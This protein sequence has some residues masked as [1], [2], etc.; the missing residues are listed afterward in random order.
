MS[1]LATAQPDTEPGLEETPLYRG[2]ALLQSGSYATAAE[3][4]LMTDG[5]DRN[6]GIVGASKAYAMLGNYQQA[7]QVCEEAIDD[8][9]YARFPLISTQL[10]EIKR[11]TGESD[12]ALNILGSVINDNFEPPVRSLVQYGSLLQFKGRKTEA[13]SHLDAAVQRY[14]DG[15]VYTS[16]DITMVALA[17]WLLDNFHDANSLFNEATRADPN[18][19]EAHTLWADLFLEKYNAA[20][21]ERGYRDALEINNR[22]VPALIGI[23]KAVGDERSVRSA[24]LVNPNS[25]PA[26]ETWG[27]L[28][29]RGDKQEEATVYFNRAL[30]V[31]PEALD[32]LSVLAAEAA[33]AERM[34][35]YEDYRQQV[36]AFSPNNPHFLGTV[37]TTLGANYR[38]TE[39]VEYARAALDA[40]PSYWNGYSLLG[41]NLVRLGEEEEGK[42]Y[43]EIGFENDPF[44]LVTSNLLTVF[45]TLETYHTVES[46]HFK[47]HLSERDATILWPYLEPLL[48]QGWDALTAKYDFEPEA[49]VLIEIFE[50]TED[51]A[52]RSI[53]LPDIGPLVGI[54]FGKVVT[55]ISPDTLSANWQEI[56]WHEFAHVIT[57]QM[58]RNRIPRWLSEG[59][60]VWEEKQSRPYW[61]REQ[62]L[63]LV[64]GIREEK[65]LPVANLSAG[66]RDAR[67]SADLGFA[68]FQSYLVVD[69]ITSEF[70]FNK[71]VEL[72]KQYEQTIEDDA[73]FQAAFDMDLDLF[74]TR[75]RRWV[76]RRVNEI[77]VYVHSDDTPDEGEG[78]GHGIRENPSAILAELYN[79][80]ALIRHMLARVEDNPR[81]FQAHLQ[82]GI[83]YFKEENFTEAK[84]HLNI[85]YELLPG[86]T[87]YPSPA[88]VLSQIYAAEDDRDAELE[89]LRLLLEHQQHDAGSAMTLAR[90]A[91]DEEEYEQ[92]TYYINRV[93]EVDPYRSDVHQLKAEL[94]RTLDNPA[95][96]V[97]EYEVLLKLEINDPVEAYTNLAEAYLQNK[98]PAA[99]KQHV[100]YALEI[101]PGFRRAQQLLLDS[102]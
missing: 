6:E 31:N 22:Y 11:L 68:Y 40:D 93:L 83:A 34:D 5:L 15:L 70:G 91:L 74:N 26:L 12:T 4:F 67:N 2:E 102:L 79:N 29:L 25:A 16:E 44:N 47:V 58:T 46:E 89:Q 87:G 23:G 35:D 38:F 37:A 57:L 61:G 52:V 88:L 17:S 100:L 7:A 45:D 41:S 14:N 21:A 3:V 60:S 73:R 80:A 96:A 43:L 84:R 13:V 75:F 72:I 62:G 24:L 90:A 66:F 101:A 27:Q 8:D 48:E 18:N 42:A 94:A 82:L 19:L 69:F 54:C 59:I 99:A 53:G 56:V 77:D 39:A 32:T 85:A 51:F 78:H 86:Y 95:E 50:N 49:P 33:L 71:L 98:Q 36:E 9:D 92:A 97:T 1:T 63:D 10:A 81:D 65:L 55:L 30:S 28:L 64:R 76:T 20:D